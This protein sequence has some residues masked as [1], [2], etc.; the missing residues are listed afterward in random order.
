LNRDYLI[1]HTFYPTL[2]EVERLVMERFGNCTFAQREYLGHGTGRTRGLKAFVARIPGGPWL[3]AQLRVRAL[4]FR[5]PP[6]PAHA[7]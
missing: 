7:R 6:M 5:Q 4:H 3:F 2:R 1:R